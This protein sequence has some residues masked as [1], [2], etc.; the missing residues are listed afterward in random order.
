MLDQG[1]EQLRLGGK[2][3]EKT[4]LGDA[5]ARRHRIERQVPGAGDPRQLLRRRQNLVAR[6]L[7]GRGRFNL[8]IGYDLT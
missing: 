3:V 4:A 8:D 2:M 7:A 6:P 5:G 1:F